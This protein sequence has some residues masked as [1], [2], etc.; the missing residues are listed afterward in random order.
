MI[1]HQ[2]PSNHHKEV[3]WASRGCCFIFSHQISPNS[4]KNPFLKPPINALETITHVE[5]RPAPIGGM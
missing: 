3:T 2:R 1:F 5:Q 4:Y